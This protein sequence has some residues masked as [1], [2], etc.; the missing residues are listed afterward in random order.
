MTRRPLQPDRAADVPV[1]ALLADAREALSGADALLIAAGAGFGVDSGLPDFRGAEGFWEAYPPYRGLGLGFRDL[2]NPRPFRTDPAIAWGFYGHRLAL[3]RETVPHAGFG[4]LRTFGERLRHGAFVFTSNVD[5][6][7]QRAGFR[8]EQI[9]EC[10]GSIH[11]VQCT[12]PCSPDLWPAPTPAPDVDLTTMRAAAPLPRCP[13]CGA[14]A[15]PNILMFGDPAWVELRAAGQEA[16]FEAWLDGLG[17][18]RLVI[19]EFGAGTAVATVRS[20]TEGLLRGRGPNV[21]LIRVNP[22]EPEG[23]SGTIGLP[24][25]GLAACEALFNA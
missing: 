15:R 5:G 17:D 24:M 9:H 22:R 2:A 14:L 11:H 16:A 19:L 10:H 3:Y 25:G 8:P 23:P 18:A 12:A 7:F 20:T 21:T 6:Q 4:L 13:A 1:Q